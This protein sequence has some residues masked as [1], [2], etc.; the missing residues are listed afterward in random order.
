MTMKTRLRFQEIQFQIYV[1]WLLAT[2]PVCDYSLSCSRHS[3]RGES[4]TFA[5]TSW[6]RLFYHFLHMVVQSGTVSSFVLI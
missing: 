5:L 3:S 2:Y 1:L 4:G 6:G